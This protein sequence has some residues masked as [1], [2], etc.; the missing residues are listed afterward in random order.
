MQLWRPYPLVQA[1]QRLQSRRDMR[2][3]VLLK[4]IIQIGFRT[5]GLRRFSLGKHNLHTESVRQRGTG[6][7]PC[8]WVETWR[9]VGSAF[10]NGCAPCPAPTQ[11]P[12]RA[13]PPASKGPAFQAPSPTADYLVLVHCAKRPNTG[14]VYACALCACV[15]AW[16]VSPCLCSESGPT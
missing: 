4:Y 8:P 3:F 13:P 2:Y 7:T 11:A 10:A 6:S 16:C 12:A 14:L 5:R 1:R 9:T 15:S